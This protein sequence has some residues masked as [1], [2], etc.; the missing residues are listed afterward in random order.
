MTQEYD[1]IIRVSEYLGKPY[2]QIVSDLRVGYTNMKLLKDLLLSYELY[3]LKDKPSVFQY[4]SEQYNYSIRYLRNFMGRNPINPE[5]HTY[6]IHD[7]IYD[8]V[9]DHIGMSRKQIDKDLD[10]YYTKPNL[11]KK[12]AICQQIKHLGMD[13]SRDEVAM[14]SKITGY[15]PITIRQ[16]KKY[17]EHFNNYSCS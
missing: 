12:L 11:V 17:K 15:S 6:K 3:A 1:I 8:L 14:Y 13:M 9:E 7:Y 4:L 5:P 16:I 2:C 10:T